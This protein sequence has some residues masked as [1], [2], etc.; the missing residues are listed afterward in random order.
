MGLKDILAQILCNKK[1]RKKALKMASK[2]GSQAM[3][4]IKTVQAGHGIFKLGNAVTN[5]N[6]FV[7][8]ASGVADSVQKFIPEMQVMGESFCDSMEIFTYFAMAA[9]TIGIGANLVLAYQGIQAL[10]LIAAKLDNISTNLAAQA[11][12]TAQRHFPRYV[13]SMIQERLSQTTDDPACDHWFFLFHPDNDWYPEFYH[14]LESNSPGPRFCGYTNQIDTIFIFMLAARRRIEERA[15]RARREGRS[16]RHIRLHLL[17]PAYQTILIFEALRIPEEIGDFIMEG[18]INSNREFVWLNLPEEQRHYVTGIGNLVPSTLGW[19]DW[20]ML[21]IGLGDEPPKL[22]EPRTLGTR[23]QSNDSG[24]HE[25]EGGD[26]G[27][28]G[29]EFDGES[30]SSREG[31]VPDDEPGSDE[32]N[33]HLATPLHHRHQRNREG[34]HRRRHREAR[35]RSRGSE[36]TLTNS[37]GRQRSRRSSR[38]QRSA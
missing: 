19:W 5:V 15:R 2:V 16:F 20:A 6:D 4:I 14:L 8:K 13:Y 9:T 33:R 30:I 34:P 26:E 25:Y 17:I 22:G 32:R 24:Q 36:S 3:P 31:M 18:R 12:L 23:Q 35:R 29:D 7:S 38:A 28:L 11:A 21:K 10:H 1:A 37:H 27:D